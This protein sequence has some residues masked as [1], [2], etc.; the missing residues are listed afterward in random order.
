MNTFRHSDHKWKNLLLFFLY[1]YLYLC[2]L[3]TPNWAPELRFIESNPWNWSGKTYAIIGSLVFY[4]VFRKSFDNHNYITFKQNN[5]SLRQILFAVILIFTITI[6]LS[7][8][9]KYSDERFEELL[10]QFTMPGIDEEFAFRGIML[11][12]LSN[13]LKSRILIGSINLGSP[14]LIITSI[15]FG[16]VHSLTIDNNW[17]IN[18][19]WF[20]FV[21][22]FAIGLLFG[23]ITIKSGSILMAIL[24]HNTLNTLPKIIFW[25]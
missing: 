14:A 10:Y 19:N 22:M 9:I 6:A 11:G 21:N 1:Y 3:A 5:N 4:F 7:F 2:L 18:Q 15:L 8:L 17:N 20:E 23:W 12:I 16:F 25:I 13:S 24:L